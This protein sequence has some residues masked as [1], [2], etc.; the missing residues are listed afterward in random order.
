MTQTDKEPRFINNSSKIIHV[1]TPDGGQKCVRPYRELHVIPGRVEDDCI[2]KGA[3]YKQFVGLL[4]PFPGTESVVPATAA[5]LD[6]MD[7]N[8]LGAAARASKGSFQGS[9]DVVSPD[10]TVKREEGNEDPEP[11]TPDAVIDKEVDNDNEEPEDGVV[12]DAEEGDEEE[13][14][15]E[16]GDEEEDC[17]L[18]DIEG[19]GPRLAENLVAIGVDTASALADMQTD[20]QLKKLVGVAGIRNAKHAKELVERAQSIL[21]WEDEDESDEDES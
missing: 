18:T 16:E 3:H 15:E 13:G 7:P 8:N 6:P 14:D 10:G 1:A 12:F 2:V 4:E 19:I 11:P 20:A 9:G 21:G 5:E 17:L